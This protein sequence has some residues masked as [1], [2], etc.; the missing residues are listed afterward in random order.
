MPR[1]RPGWKPHLSA[2]ASRSAAPPWAAG[3]GGSGHGVGAVRPQGGERPGAALGWGPARPRFS[4]DVRHGDRGRCC[5]RAASVEKGR[6]TGSGSWWMPLV[7]AQGHC[8]LWLPLSPLASSSSRGGIAAGCGSGCSIALA[9]PQRVAGWWCAARPCGGR[10]SC[11]LLMARRQCGGCKRPAKAHQATQVW[12][13][14]AVGRG[15]ADRA[16]ADSGQALPAG[17][18]D[19][20]SGSGPFLHARW[21]PFQR[22]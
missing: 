20:R 13:R 11:R 9:P 8:R 14:G 1:T 2:A 15:C 10:G 17:V 19:H 5:A 22:L 18:A 7:E 12:G 21:N 4:T 3:G 6:G 16:V